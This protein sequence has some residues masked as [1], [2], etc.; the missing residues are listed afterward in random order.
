MDM[1]A[2]LD[3]AEFPLQETT[4]SSGFIAAL[5]IVLLGNAIPPITIARDA[6]FVF[7]FLDLNKETKRDVLRSS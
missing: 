2:V 6:S 1:A 3:C 4:R 5:V 7:C